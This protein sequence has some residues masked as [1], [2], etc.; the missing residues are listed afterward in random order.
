MSSSLTKFMKEFGS[1][2]KPKEQKPVEQEEKVGKEQGIEN[3]FN[4]KGEDEG[5]PTNPEPVKEKPVL[6]L[7]FHL[8]VPAEPVVEKKEPVKEQVVSASAGTNGA[9]PVVNDQKQ[10]AEPTKPKVATATMQNNPAEEEPPMIITRRGRGRPPMSSTVSEGQPRNPEPVSKPEPTPA[11]ASV[12]VRTPESAP[13]TPKPSN[14]VQEAP[15]RPGRKPAEKPATNEPSEEWIEEAFI[16]SETSPAF[17]QQWITLVKKAYASDKDTLTNR[18][19]RMGRFRFD[20]TGS[21]EILP[22]LDT[23]QKSANDLLRGK[24]WF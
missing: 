7:K 20:S 12:S 2:E 14:P 6:K 13:V 4:I 23:S 1:E 19:V 3:L 16:R 5:L 21:I 10:I 9:I 17:K 8:N 15:K 11:S 24:A 18:K 22:D